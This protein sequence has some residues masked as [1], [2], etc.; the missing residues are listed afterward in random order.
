MGLITKEVEISIKIND[1]SYWENLGYKIPKVLSSESYYKRYGKRY[2][3][4]RGTKIKVKVEDLKENSTIKVK[5][6]CDCCGKEKTI[7][8][9]TYKHRSYDDYYCDKCSSKREETKNKIAENHHHISGKDHYNYNYD[10]TD[11]ERENNRNR[12][13]DVK[14]MEWAKKVK[15]RDNYTCKCCGG[16]GSRS[17]NSHHL[18]GWDNFEEKRYEVTNGVTLCETCHRNFHLIYGY[19]D[20]TKEQFEEWIGKAVKVL[21]YDGELYLSKKIY[22][23]EEDKVYDSAKQLKEEWNTNSDIYG[24]CN[25]KIKK[26][27][28]KCKDGTISIYKIPLETIK[29]KHIMWLSEAIEKGYIKEV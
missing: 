20:N 2:C 9:S 10:M 18:D 7:S 3:V 16:K 11:E 12:T 6:K 1:I 27:K 5:V 24:V 29:G 25:H 19:G 4:Q 17:L 15:A 26:R 28:H 13:L 14:Y 23:V 22:C 8:N 21:N